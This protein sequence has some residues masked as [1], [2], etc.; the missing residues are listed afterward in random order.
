[1][2]LQKAQSTGSSWTFASLTPGKAYIAAV[3]AVGTA[4]PSDWTQSAPQI[5]V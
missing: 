2:V 3:N 5:A 4:G 1:V